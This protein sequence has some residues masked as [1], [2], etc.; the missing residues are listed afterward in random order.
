MQELNPQEIV[1]WHIAQA[2]FHQDLAAQM[3]R[4]FNIQ[5]IQKAKREHAPELPKFGVVTVD[6][7]E[8]RV[9]TRSGRIKDIARFFNA[10]EKSIQALLEPASKVYTGD[11]GWLKV[12]E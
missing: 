6:Q 10:D 1:A 4:Q 9:R 3:E 7:L 12:R 11:R 5:P 8:T 2:K